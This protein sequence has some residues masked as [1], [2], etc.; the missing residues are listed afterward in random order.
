MKFSLYKDSKNTIWRR[1]YFK[2][3]A[4]SIEEA[5]N[6]ILNLDAYPVDSELLVDTEEGMLPSEN[7]GQATEE[8]FDTHTNETLYGNKQD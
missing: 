8:I 1:D 7:G 6:Q 3:E 5:I 4:D 2:I